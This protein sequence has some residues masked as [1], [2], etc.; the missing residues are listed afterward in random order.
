MLIVEMEETFPRNNINSN[1]SKY[2]FIYTLGDSFGILTYY[3]SREKVI[4]V[5]LIFKENLIKLTIHN[6]ILAIGSP[7]IY[8]SFI[9]CFFFK[10]R[11]LSNRVTKEEKMVFIQ[12]FIISMFNTFTG[13]T[14]S[15]NMHYEVDGILPL[16]IAHFSWLHIHGFPPVIYLTLNKTVQ[17][18]TKTLLNK[19]Y[20]RFKNSQNR[21][22]TIGGFIG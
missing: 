12:V 4:T 17:T 13:I 22:S 8:G 10:S 16:M 11:E 7:I 2:L 3:F 5:F 14:Y 9:I 6:T 1:K 19:I 20:S 18:D 15:Y 21:V